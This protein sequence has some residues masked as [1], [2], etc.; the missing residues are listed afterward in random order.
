MATTPP[1]FDNRNFTNNSDTLH[2]P[3]GCVATYEADKAWREAFTNI[4]E[5]Q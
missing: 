2:V 1:E 5:Q 4:V 3:A